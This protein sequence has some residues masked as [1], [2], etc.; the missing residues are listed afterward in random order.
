MVRRSSQHRRRDPALNL[1][2]D[3]ATVILALNQPDL[4]SKTASQSLTDTSNRRTI[5]CVTF[6]E[7]SVKSSAGRLRLPVEMSGLAAHLE[8]HLVAEF[9]ELSVEDVLHQ[10]GLP[11]IHGDP[12]DRILICQA[13][14]R[15][16]VILTPDKT[17]RQ[18][19]VPSIW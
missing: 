19:D 11:K 8:Q 4:L 10:S 5:S 17:I 1:L 2:L 14:A 16:L 18:Y 15:D 9:I 6:W 13:L 7:I 3:T 12:F